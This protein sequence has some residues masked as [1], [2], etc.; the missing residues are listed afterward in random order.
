MRNLILYLDFA[1]LVL[2]FVTIADIRK[3][4][5]DFLM[6]KRNTKH[7][8]EIHRAQPLKE[9]ITLSYISFHLKKY[10]KEFTVYHRLYLAVLYT[11]IPQYVILITCN[12]IL[13]IKSMYVL[14]VFAAIKLMIC[15]TIRLHVDSN[16]ISIYRQK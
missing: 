5:V 2:D 15:I 7:A 9:R 4:L 6:V 11:L 16:R 3:F 14:A 10:A 13:G 1:M 8:W 12:C